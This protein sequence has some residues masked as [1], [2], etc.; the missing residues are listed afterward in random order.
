MRQGILITAYRD[1]PMLE[2]LVTYFDEDFE[3][4]IHVD[5][6]CRENLAALEGKERVH[7]FRTYAV[8]WGD[9]KHL[10]AIVMLMKEAYRHTDLEYFHLITGSDYPCLPLVA[11][12]SFCE[13]HRNDNYLEHF[14]LPHSNWG[15]KGGLNRI[16]YWW[17]RPNSTRTNGAWLTRKLVNLQRRLGIKRDFKFFGSKLYGGGTYW[18]LSREAVGVAVDYLTQH[19]DYLRRFCHTSIA[20]EICLPTLLINSNLPII[21]NYKRYID[22]GP[23]GANPQVLTE[24]DYDNIIASGALFARKLESGTSDKL[25]EFIQ[26]YE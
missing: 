21:N 23:D 13:E 15:A 18:S 9:Y 22:W 16:Q 10:L 14:P 11:F 8:E 4:F 19:P 26:K 24:E 17:L 6:R 12:K 5:K 2:K 25:I 7:L 3:L 20:E 1:I